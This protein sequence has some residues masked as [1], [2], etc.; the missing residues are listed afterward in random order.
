M[1]KSVIAKGDE[2]RYSPKPI[3]SHKR[4]GQ[5]ID[6][7]GC[8]GASD[9][10]AVVDITGFG[11]IFVEVKARGKPM[12]DGQRWALENVVIGLRRA[13]MQAAA[14]IVEHDQGDTDKAIFLKDCTVRSVFMKKSQGWR[15]P[16]KQNLLCHEA[17]EGFRRAAKD[18][19]ANYQ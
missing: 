11:T 9:F 8:G 14:L 18:S 17:I 6:F 16:K 19:K 7:A 2:S 13:G 10:D 3:S 4:L 5:V 12:P 1:S 15:A